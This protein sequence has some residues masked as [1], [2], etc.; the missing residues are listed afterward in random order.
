MAGAYSFE[1]L[2]AVLF[3]A[4]DPAYLEPFFR[5]PYGNGRE[6]FEALLTV[7]QRVDQ[8]INRTT[9]ALFIQPWSGQTDPPAMGG[10]ATRLVVRVTRS[11]SIELA[12]TLGAGAVLVQEV[13]RD[14]GDAGGQ[15]VITGRQYTPTADLTF[16]PGEAGPKEV[17]V[18]ATRIGY[19]F[20]NPLPG[21]LKSL[22]QPG[23]AYQNS[24]A[25]IVQTPSVAQ[26]TA[27]AVP[28]VL[29][30]EHVG[31]YLALVG[32]ANV[33]QVRRVVGYLPA[34]PGV[35][36]GTVL[37]AATF[38]GRSLLAAPTGTFLPDEP[39]VQIDALG[40]TI[41]AEGVMRLVAGGPPWYAVVDTANGTFAPTA[42]T[43]GPIT[44]LLS[45]AT[46][47]VEDVT[48][49]G[50]LVPE[51]GTAA[52]RILAWPE[53]L[54]VE[55]LNPEGSLVIPGSY[56]MLDALGEERGI[57]RAPG[58]DDETYRTRVATIADTVSPN[59]VRRIGNRIWSPYGAMVCLREVGLR[60]FPGVYGDAPPGDPSNLSKY[61]YDQDGLK[62]R[63]VKTGEFF[64]GERVYQDNGG[65]LTTGRVTTTIP[66]APPGSLVPPVDPNFLEVAAIR[67]QRFLVGV[68]VVGEVSGASFL[69][70]AVLYGLRPQDRFKLNL[71]Y[72]EFRA[73]FLLGVPPSNLG[74]FGIP[75]DA[76][77]PYNAFDAAPYLT[78][79]DGFPLTAAVLNRNTW[80]AVDR[81]RAG[82][83][84]FDLYLESLGCS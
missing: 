66:A 20:A 2:L 34:V 82:G 78:F 67:G 26:L 84:G 19:G 30:P 17:E 65:I 64:D 3:T 68:P 60:L 59:A 55:L 50:Q 18:I 29:V 1:E 57:A 7:L 56:P 75:Y 31:Q 40:P 35:D 47:T 41:I 45:G 48:Q 44:G 63:G 72:L 43:V 51:V 61:A 54:G 69:P 71:D 5:G 49:Q 11:R 58:E 25:T 12:L 37:L 10:S 8:A 9:Q 80:Q 14:W 52:W 36:G 81:A 4:A 21:T 28:D 76:P 74:E 46:Y 38:V 6:A 22:F 53:D 42:G 83:V 70:A 24:G 73:F 13:A 79:S 16:A 15:D 33:G 77:H 27:R 23:A 39:V 32:G 62:L